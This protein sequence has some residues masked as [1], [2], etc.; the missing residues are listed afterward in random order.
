MQTLPKKLKK[1][2][3]HSSGDK[4]G[5]CR[6]HKKFGEKS[7]TCNNFCKFFEDQRIN[8]IIDIAGKLLK[9]NCK[10]TNFDFLV[11]TGAAVSIIPYNNSANNPDGHLWAANNSLIPTFGTVVLDI[12]IGFE[13]VFSHEFI[14]ADIRTP[15]LG[16][17]FLKKHNM[18]VDIP[19]GRLL[20]TRSKVCQL[21]PLTDTDVS[22]ISVITNAEVLAV[23]E[24]YPELRIKDNLLPAI[25][26]SYEHTIPTV[27]AST[28]CRPRRLSPAHLRVLK[29]KLDELLHQG[30]IVPSNSEYAAPIHLAPKR[31]DFRLVGDYRQLN[32]TI[33]RDTYPIPNIA[34]FSAQLSGM[35]MF[36]NLDLKSAYLC[37]PIKLEDQGKS[38][39]T[40]PLGAY[41]Y[42]RLP[43]G[44]S[45]A[46]QSFQRYIDIALRNIYWVDESGRRQDVNI[47]VYIDD[48]L[49]ASKDLDHHLKDLDAV[50]HRLSQ[51]GLKL[52]MEKCNFATEKLTFLG[53]DISPEGFTASKDKVEAIQQLPLPR[54]LGELKRAV[55]MVIYYAKFLQRCSEI[56]APINDMLKGYKKSLKNVKIDWAQHQSAEQAFSRAKSELARLTLLHYPSGKG[57]LRIKCDAS[58]VAV[59]GALEEVV[60]GEPRPI[61]FFSRKLTPLE[62]NASTFTRELLAIY[63]CVRKFE[64]FLKGERFQI[65][66]DHKAI[67][68][69]MEKSSLDRAI[70]KEGRML[71]YLSQ[72]DAEFFHITGADNLLADIL[73]RPVLS[74]FEKDKLSPTVSTSL[75]EQIKT[76]QLQ[77]EELRKYVKNPSASSSIKLQ[78]MNNVYVEKIKNTIRPFV[79]KTL[80][81]QVFENLHS[82]RHGGVKATWNMIRT[83]YVW[84]KMRRD[85]ACWTKACIKCQKTKITRHNKA[86]I[87]SFARNASKKF[88]QINVDLVGPLPVCDG[89]RYILTIVDRYSSW[90]EM[91]PLPDKQSETVAKAFYLHWIAKYGVPAICHSD[92]GQEFRG[93]KFA[94]MLRNLGCEHRFSLPYSPH[95]NGAIEVKHRSLKAALRAGDKNDWITSLS[96]WLLAYRADFKTELKCSPSE[97]TFGEPIRL[98]GDMFDHSYTADITP[99]G[100]VDRIQRSIQDVTPKYRE[101]HIKGVID[102]NLYNRDKVFVR[103]ETKT[104]LQDVY[105]GPYKILQRSDKYF[106]I[107][108][109]GKPVKVSLNRLKSAILLDDREKQAKVDKSDNCDNVDG[110]PPFLTGI[111]DVNE[112]I[113]TI[114]RTSV[115]Y[116]YNL[117]SR[118]QA[119]NSQPQNNNQTS[120]NNQPQPQ[121]NN[122]TSPNNQSQHQTNNQTLPNNQPQPQP[123]NQTSPTNRPQSQTTNPNPVAIQPQPQNANQNTTTINHTTQS[124]HTT[125]QVILPQVVTTIPDPTS[126]IPQ[127]HT[128]QA[129]NII[130]QFPTSQVSNLIPPSGSIPDASNIRSQVS[131]ATAATNVRL[132]SQPQVEIHMTGDD[133]GSNQ[134]LPATEEPVPR[135]PITAV[136]NQT[137]IINRSILRQNPSNADG[138]ASVSPRLH[139]LQ[140][141]AKARKTQAPQLDGSNTTSVRGRSQ[142]L[143]GRPPKTGPVGQRHTSVPGRFTGNSVNNPRGR[144]SKQFVANG[145]KRTTNA[146]PSVKPKTHPVGRK[147]SL[148]KLVNDTEPS[149]VNAETGA[150]KN[151]SLADGTRVKLANPSKLMKDLFLTPRTTR[152]GRTSRPPQK[153]K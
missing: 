143:R 39:I 132:P 34:D 18:I 8:S 51:H 103:N 123:I 145:V 19:N 146:E 1:P 15:I 54:T 89:M 104:G 42:T 136:E 86:N 87:D 152:S 64:Y 101:V 130:P 7:W 122:Q 27:G 55:G 25:K 53:Y 94:G 144:G 119:H 117:R 62:Q 35:S 78:L 139:L 74:V 58:N 12:D 131:N 28:F 5:Y 72:F 148:R 76:E 121:T 93:E 40:T 115:P 112:P 11:D 69:A 29:E 10:R 107:E 106:E 41:K 68:G 36:S 151:K 85:I 127:P 52:A 120:P 38:T 114:S 138:N 14:K 65:F 37:I 31:N 82:L 57:I 23:L 33:T 13:K 2:E 4:L 32:N 16:V 73:S 20:D 56:L 105:M 118:S 46:A 71:Q 137:P 21:L 61:A 113:I 141:A 24:K 84:P 45:N 26:G 70:P 77:C 17:D 91:L 3:G 125:P 48:I 60:D 63:L 95:Q 116:F 142:S 79:P 102:P 6:G 92:N 81:Y 100:Y 140:Q 124:P 49:I 111:A 149:A 110:T 9:V 22:V 50:L 44:L 135:N 126:H 150:K 30:I 67:L 47:F 97:L 134:L 133:T 99:G 153:F 80:R 128:F 98:P 108:I 75:L 88:E 96:S 43:Y 66:T 147:P 90:V 129:S 59:G 109:K 83:R